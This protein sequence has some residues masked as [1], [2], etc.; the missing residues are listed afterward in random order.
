[1]DTFINISG[2]DFGY[3]KKRVLT[4]LEFEVV[5]GGVYGLLG[6]NGTGKT[7]IINLITGLLHADKGSVEVL[8][9]KSFD[10][11]YR[12]Y[13]NLFTVPEEFELPSVSFNDY[14]KS[15]APFYPNFSHEEVANYIERFKI[16]AIERLDRMSMGQRKKCLIAFCFA[17]NCKIMILDEPTNG[18]D[19]P[20]KTIFRSIVAEKASEDRVIIISTHQIRDIDSILDSLM[21]IDNDEMIVNCSIAKIEETF[22]FVESSRVQNAIYTESNI[23]IIENTEELET[24]INIEIL[25]NATLSQ[26]T[27]VTRL[28]NR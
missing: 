12:M 3:S 16:N 23:S 20:S 17:T 4:N 27:I 19:I 21:I 26:K 14:I 25:F 11:D 28:L 7:T 5:K 9:Y 8:G 6:E 24:P 15:Y 10:K 18:L 2:L 1:M 22:A 13:Q